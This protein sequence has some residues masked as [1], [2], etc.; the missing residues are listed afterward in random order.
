MKVTLRVHNLFIENSAAL[1][2]H[3]MDVINQLADLL[4]AKKAD[5]VELTLVDDLD[6]SHPQA[7]SLD[8]ERALALFAIL[9]FKKIDIPAS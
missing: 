2:S 9:N 1:R 3:S 5:R 7:Q 4:Y 8:A 6:K